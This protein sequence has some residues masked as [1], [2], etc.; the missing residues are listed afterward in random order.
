MRAEHYVYFALKSD[1]VPAAEITARL[2][3]EPDM[4]TVKGSRRVDPPRPACHIWAVECRTSGLTVDEQ[5]DHVLQRLLPAADLIGELA[6]DLDRIDQCPGSVVLQVVRYYEDDDPAAPDERDLLGWH[7][8]I[9][10]I[11][12]LARTR[13]ALDV[14]EYGN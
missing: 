4:V 14:D 11:D 7:L 9:R 12:F 13:A 10:V 3:I 2:G 5:I 6:Q 8:D 1:C